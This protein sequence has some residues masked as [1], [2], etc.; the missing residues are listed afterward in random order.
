MLRS[1]VLLFVPCQVLREHQRRDG[2][3]AQLLGE[4]EAL[5]RDGARQLAEQ[6]RLERARD[7]ALRA[8]DRAK[9]TAH[10]VVSACPCGYACVGLGS[11]QLP[12][13]LAV[14]AQCCCTS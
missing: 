1:C 4:Q 14:H 11:S 8:A 5:R 3:M 9:V 10:A 2:M 13:G 7:D 12:A 6:A